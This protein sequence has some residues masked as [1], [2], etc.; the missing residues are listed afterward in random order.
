MPIVHVMSV[1]V[2]HAAVHVGCME[3]LAAA[4]AV[5]SGCVRAARHAADGH[6]GACCGAD[7]HGAC[8]GVGRACGVVTVPMR[9]QWFVCACARSQRFC[10]CTPLQIQVIMCVSEAKHIARAQA[11]ASTGCRMPHHECQWGSLSY[12]DRSPAASASV[13]QWQCNSCG[14]P[15]VSLHEAV[16]VVAAAL[17]RCNQRGEHARDGRKDSE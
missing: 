4:A 12:D 5:V 16:G 13:G 10:S 9:W 6:G 11:S 15:A 1:V 2:A 8:N 17:F 14:P 3:A 7:G